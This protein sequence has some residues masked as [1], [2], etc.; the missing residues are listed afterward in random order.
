M[1]TRQKATVSLGWFAMVVGTLLGVGTLY[2]AVVSSTA[3]VKESAASTFGS[4]EDSRRLSSI[5]WSER[6]ATC[7]AT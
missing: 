4:A 3:C 1:S 6:C 7:F 2:Y 5:A